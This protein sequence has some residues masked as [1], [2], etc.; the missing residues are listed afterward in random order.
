MSLSRGYRCY[1]HFFRFATSV[2]TSFTTNPWLFGFR[3]D[4]R[5]SSRLFCFPYAGGGPRTYA[6]W[7]ESLPSTAEVGLVQ[8]PGRA[9]RFNEPPITRLSD[10]IEALGHGLRPNLDK[11]FAFF[12]HSLGAL[13]CFELARYIRREFGLL[14]MHLFV[15]ARGAPQTDPLVP[16]IHA[17]PEPAFLE[18]I[19]RLNG[20]PEEVFE[21]PELLEMIVPILR[22]DFAL[23][24]TYSYSPEPPLD[25]PITVLGGSLDTSTNY[26][27]LAAWQDQ[28]TSTFSMRL[29][30]GDHF[31]I[32]TARQFILEVL[33]EELKLNRETPRC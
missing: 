14:P 7:A 11:P 23:N 4:P 22:A 12:G 9:G 18:E 1:I 28:T 15:S 25:C 26:D 6:K 3:P 19:R 24:E 8:F 5:A 13:L 16:P 31:F 30:P 17:L 29:L 33:K 2:A 10:L 20:T 32:N 21:T 27:C